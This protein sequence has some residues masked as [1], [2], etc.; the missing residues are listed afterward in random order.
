MTD[1]FGCDECGGMH[2]SQRKAVGVLLAL[3]RWHKYRGVWQQAQEAR[4]SG[5][6][7]LPSLPHLVRSSGR[8][9]TAC[10]CTTSLGLVAVYGIPP[11][12]LPPFSAY[13]WNH[14]ITS[15]HL[16]YTP[17]CLRGLPPYPYTHPHPPHDT[18]QIDEISIY[19]QVFSIANVTFKE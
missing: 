8:L 16:H 5:I 13:G 12:P 9:A 14:H 7:S 3:H 4:S 2:S 6:G 18:W 15:H 17:R 19:T 11:H 1:P 10:S